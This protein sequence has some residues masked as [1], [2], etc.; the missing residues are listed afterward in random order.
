MS[1]ESLIQSFGLP[2]LFLGG[3]VEGDGAGLVGGALAH[4]GAFPVCAAWA[5]LSL[6]A[7]LADQAW[8][9]LA[10]SHRDS[11]RLARLVARP[12]AQRF[13]GL[14]DRRPALASLAFR[15][16]F[17]LRTLGPVALGLS[18][19]PARIFI[20]CNVIAVAIW[21]ALFTALGYGAGQILHRIFGRLAP[22]VHLGLVLGL[23][24]AALVIVALV[25]HL[26]SRRL[27]P[28]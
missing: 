15:F 18:Q 14:A 12:A 17:G 28:G 19:V 25:H 24:A 20:P 2:A 4:R 26:R 16:V 6:G 8:F 23:V 10:R 3:L 7:L 22:G 9:A 1:V 21:G 5:A 11:P 27:P 13:L